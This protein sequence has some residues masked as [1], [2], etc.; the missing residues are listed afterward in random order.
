[1]AHLC[2]GF[3]GS[4]DVAVGGAAIALD[5]GDDSAGSVFLFET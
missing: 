3:E 4:L 2:Q 5:I 1:M